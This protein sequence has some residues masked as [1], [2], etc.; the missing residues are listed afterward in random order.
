MALSIPILE[1]IYPFDANNTYDFKF[2]YDRGGNQYTKS[3]LVISTNRGDGTDSIIYDEVMES[4][5]P[6]HTYVPSMATVPLVNG[7]QYKVKIRVGDNNL[8]SD[9]SEWKLFYVHTTPLVDIVN[10]SDDGFIYNHIETFQVSYITPSIEEDPLMS[11]QFYLYDENMIL[12][13]EYPKKYAISHSSMIEQT[14][15]NLESGVKY[16]LRLR[17]ESSHGVIVNLTKEFTPLY[18]FP[19]LG[20][21]TFN[22]D[23]LTD[24]PSVKISYELYQI[25]GAQTNGNSVSYE[26]N[27]WINLVGKSIHYDKDFYIKDDFIIKLW[28]KNLEN[29]KVIC[30]ISGNEGIIEFVYLYKHIHVYKYKNGSKYQ[31]HIA[32]KTVINPL[33]NTFII[34][35]QV[36]NMMNLTC[37]Q[38]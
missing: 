21:T 30:R 8:W 13:N 12:I 18:N 25:E 28:C 37:Q 3:N 5:H 33:K 1:N 26:D 32:C 20:E 6:F 22:V 2:R 27:T 31:N 23:N 17:T 38:G 9:F 4:Y 24:K 15:N 29:N 35:K 34:L 11:Y 10:I 14:V 16:I 7:K 19:I 36:E